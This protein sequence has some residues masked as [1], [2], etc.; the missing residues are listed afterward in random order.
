M[1][2]INFVVLCR[3]TSTMK[4]CKAKWNSTTFV[5]KYN[6]LSWYMAGIKALFD[7]PS[8]LNNLQ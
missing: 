7:L 3:P 8:Q 1:W 2:P 5:N 4:P 6:K